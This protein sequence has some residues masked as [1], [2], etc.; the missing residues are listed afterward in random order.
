MHYFIPAVVTGSV[1]ALI[2]IYL[3]LGRGRFWLVSPEKTRG[4]QHTASVVVVVPARDEAGFIAQSITSLLRQHY[5]GPLHVILVDDGSRDGT[6]HIATQAAEHVEQRSR[7][8]VVSGKPLPPGWSGK[9]WALQQGIEVARDLQPNLLLF[10]DADVV[11]APETVAQVVG[12]AQQG[13]YDLVSFMVKLHCR[14]DAEKLLIPAFVFFFFMLYPPAWI[15]DPKRRAAG[16][17]GGCILIKPESLERAGGIEAIRDQIIDDCALARRVKDSGGRV[18]LGT[19]TSSQSIRPYRSAFDIGSMISRTAFNQLHHS[20][21]MLL[22]AVVG[23]IVTYLVPI[24]L[25]FSQYASLAFLGAVLW[26]AISVAYLPTV[27]LYRLH[28]LWALTLPLAAVFYL[29]A[30]LHSAVR[31]WLGRGGRWKGRVQDPARTSAAH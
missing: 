28:P 7:L 16:A 24:G 21:L 5:G 23:L 20:I 9:L 10:T 29:G 19:T 31:Y 27:I 22:V 8:T 25:L 4:S 11:H 18:W 6:A 13:G 3:L 1:S 14:R 12:I 26:F 17:A 15:S 30:T 2:W